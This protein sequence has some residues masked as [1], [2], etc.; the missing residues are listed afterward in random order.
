M[1]PV[2]ENWLVKHPESPGWILDGFPRS[3]PQ[4]EFLDGHLAE[5]G[6]ELDARG[7]P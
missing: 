7:C 6:L 3:L 1:W 5:N 4:A 2:V